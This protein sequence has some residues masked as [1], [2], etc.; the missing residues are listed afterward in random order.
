MP[1]HGIRPLLERNL[2][3]FRCPVQIEPGQNGFSLCFVRNMVA[4]EIAEPLI[5]LKNHAAMLLAVPQAGLGLNAY[6]GTL[7]FS[8]HI[9]HVGNQ[10]LTAGAP[11]LAQFLFGRVA[12]GRAKNQRTHGA[13]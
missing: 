10:G 7:L 6:V 4:G 9:V 3:R 5:I 1:P 11:I 2:P 12:A 8:Q 13:C